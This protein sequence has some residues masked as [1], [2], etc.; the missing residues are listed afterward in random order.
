MGRGGSRGKKT[1]TITELNKLIKK[2][3]FMPEAWEVVSTWH[4]QKGSHRAQAVAVCALLEQALEHSISTHFPVTDEE[5]IDFFGGAEGEGLSFAAK[6][7]LAYALGIIENKVR[8]ELN[9]IRRIRNV[10]AHTR[11]KVSFSTKEIS[12]AINT[13]KLLE[14]SKVLTAVLGREPKSAKDKFCFVVQLLYLYLSNAEKD[15]KNLTYKNSSYY[16]TI[17]L[18]E[19][20]PK[21]A[22]SPSILQQLTGLAALSPSLRIPPPPVAGVVP[23]AKSGDEQSHE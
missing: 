23:A 8:G 9:L 17:L 16:Y 4:D 3:R 20:Y 19:R 12:N 14:S 7:N 13:F 5:K 2:R 15:L 6:I 1:N 10:F 21:P 11:E 22:H 18:K